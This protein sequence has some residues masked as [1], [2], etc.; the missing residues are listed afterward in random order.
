[1]RSASMELK[2]VSGRPVPRF[3]IWNTKGDGYG[4]FPADERTIF[5]LVSS[6]RMRAAAYINSYEQ[7]LNGRLHAPDQLLHFM[8]ALMLEKE[9]LNQSMLAG[10]IGEIYWRYLGAEARTAFAQAWEEGLWQGMLAQQDAGSRKIFFR[11]FQNLA[12]TSAGLDRLYTT[13]SS[14]TPPPGLTLNDDEYTSL[15]LQL[16]VKAH[17]DTSILKAQLARLTNADRRARLQFLI[18][19]LSGETAVRDSFFASL[20]DPLV[21]KNESWVADALGYLHHPLRAA[22]SIRYLEESL[23]LLEEIQRTGDIFFP[24]A[25]LNSTLG[26]HRS[27]EAADIVRRFLDTHPDYP[28]PLK[29]KILQAADGLFRGA[30]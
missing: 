24:S 6:P 13:W 17:P 5:G 3:I 21:R 9:S 22:S 10:Y 29:R 11:L 4:L 19:A 1:M 30:E 12:T 18:P 27:K 28:L 16:A 15:A 23:S 8:A 14:R 2:Q 7:M 20:R 26:G 25:W